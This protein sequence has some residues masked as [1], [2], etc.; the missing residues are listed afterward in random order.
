MTKPAP[1][2]LAQTRAV[3][4]GA[5]FG[6]RGACARGQYDVRYSQCQASGLLPPAWAQAGSFQ[7]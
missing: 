2:E 1:T 7:P 3:L 5:G 6:A 4:R